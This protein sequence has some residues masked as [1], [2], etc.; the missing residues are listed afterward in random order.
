[1]GTGRIK[2]LEPFMVV[3]PDTQSRLG[4]DIS[5]LLKAYIPAKGNVKV[6]ER[7]DYGLF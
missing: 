4:D 6:N 3:R 1:M 5:S 7:M 2:G